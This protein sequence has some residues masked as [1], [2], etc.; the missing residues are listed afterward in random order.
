[1]SLSHHE[2][3]LV[4]VAVV[5]EV[6]MVVEASS[7]QGAPRRLVGE[8]GPGGHD[9][10]VRVVGEHDVPH[11]AVDHPCAAPAPPCTWV[12]DEVV[13]AAQ[14][15]ELDPGR[16]P[17]THLAVRVVSVLRRRVPALDPP[18]GGASILSNPVLDV[19]VDLRP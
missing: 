15:V 6:G 2:A 3:T 14:A 17:A 8:V 12:T 16:E 9:S 7:G 4:R 10:P 1:M 18:E 11:E 5:H 13:D 19:V